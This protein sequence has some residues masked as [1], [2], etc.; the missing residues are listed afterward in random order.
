LSNHERLQ[1]PAFDK[2]RPNGLYQF[3]SGTRH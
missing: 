2:L 3:N 1:R